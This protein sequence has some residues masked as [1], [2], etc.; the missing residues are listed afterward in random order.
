MNAL[1]INDIINNPNEQDMKNYFK[2]IVTSVLGTRIIA[3]Q[4]GCEDAAYPDPDEMGGGGPWTIIFL[5]IGI[6]F[7]IWFVFFSED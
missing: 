7:F 3:A 6:L 2:T 1:L 4:V 5:I